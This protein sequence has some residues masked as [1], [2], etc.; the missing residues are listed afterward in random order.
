MANERSAKTRHLVQ[1]VCWRACVRSFRHATV[2]SAPAAAAE[3][4][5]RGVQSTH[6]S[7]NYVAGAGSLIKMMQVGCVMDL[8]LRITI[9]DLMHYFITPGDVLHTELYGNTY[10]LFLLCTRLLSS[11]LVPER[12]KQCWTP[13]TRNKQTKKGFSTNCSVTTVVTVWDFQILI[14][15]LIFVDAPCIQHQKTP[16]SAELRIS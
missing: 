9:G 10:Q 3:Q 2:S 11:S 16:S 6:T 8:T 13:V 15:D 14:C 12:R 1:T 7:F 5:R 4:T